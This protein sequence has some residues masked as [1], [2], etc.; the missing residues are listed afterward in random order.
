[1]T[2]AVILS[3]MNNP[4]L[5]AKTAYSFRDFWVLYAL[6]LVFVVIKYFFP[7][8]LFPD[9]L[10]MHELD[11]KQFFWLVLTTVGALLGILVA[12]LLLSFQLIGKEAKRRKESNV[13]HNK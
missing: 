2:I 4:S 12:A 9:G 7:E 13:L 11:P 5:T 1:M 6:V 10:Q 3:Y 8:P